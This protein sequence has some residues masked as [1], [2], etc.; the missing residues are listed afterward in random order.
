MLQEIVFSFLPPAESTPAVYPEQL[1]QPA[2][3]QISAPINERASES[4]TCVK[5][6]LSETE[7]APAPMAK[8]PKDQGILNISEG[9]REQST[10]S[11]CKY[12][13]ILSL[14]SFLLGYG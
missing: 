13:P 2:I 11:T 7:A 4:T 12:F 1:E 6:P 9:T 10:M 3:V 5:R 14:N 8:R